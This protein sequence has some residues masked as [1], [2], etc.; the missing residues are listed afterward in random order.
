MHVTKEL[1]YGFYAILVVLF[2][3]AGRSMDTTSHL[4]MLG[5]AGLGVLL[6]ALLWHFWGKHAV[7][8]A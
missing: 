4:H 6:S 1:L 5:G 2:A 3:L 7:E 8:T